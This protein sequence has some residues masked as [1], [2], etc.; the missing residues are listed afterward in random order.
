M[1][2]TPMRTYP[3]VTSYG[4]GTAGGSFNLYTGTN[5]TSKKLVFHQ[6]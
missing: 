5:S 1:F 4:S 6:S 2:P 3:T